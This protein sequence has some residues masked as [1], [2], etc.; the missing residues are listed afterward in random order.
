LLQRFILLLAIVCTPALATE[1]C[2]TADATGSDVRFSVMQSGAPFGG[3]FR[4][5][6]G[7]V[8]FNQGRITRIAATLDP[9]SVDSGLPELDTVLQDKDFFAVRE[10][11]RVS[12]VSTSVQSKGDTHTVR[13]VLEIKGKRREVEVGLRSQQIG[14]KTSVSGSLTIDRLQY[15]IGTGDWSNTQWLGAD[16]KLDIKAAL[17]RKK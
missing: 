6:S 3:S 15:D 11:P 9:A 8:C 17:T 1:D 7:E 12:F 2:Y 16:V 5:F 4:R 13:G 14:D 10:H